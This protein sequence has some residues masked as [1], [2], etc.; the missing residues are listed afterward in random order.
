MSVQSEAQGGLLRV[1]VEVSREEEFHEVILLVGVVHGAIGREH[2]LIEATAYGYQ[3]SV[4]LVFS[5]CVL[6][7]QPLKALACVP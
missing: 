3:V 1:Y 6:L 5:V 2:L 4:G 7:T